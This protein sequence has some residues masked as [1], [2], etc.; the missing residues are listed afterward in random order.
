M[1]Y[2]DIYEGFVPAAWPLVG[3]KYVSLWPIFN[4]ADSS[5][6]V[7]VA[8]ILLLQG[9]FFGHDPQA[10]APAALAGPPPSSLA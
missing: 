9:R 8:L 7:G 3:G 4:V 2:A 6:F 10:A 1:I 5:I